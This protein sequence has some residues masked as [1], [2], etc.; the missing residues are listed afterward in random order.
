M[1]LII[2]IPCFNEAQTL[3]LTYKTLPTRIEGIDSIETLVIDDGSIDNTAEIA[4]E[5]GVTHVYRY[6]Q[7]KGLARAFSLGMEKSL[8]LGADIIVNTDAD[9]QY[10]GQ[11]IAKIVQPI[12]EEK[13]DVVVGDRQ[14]DSIEHFSLIKKKLQKIGS[15]VIRKLSHTEVRDTVSGFRAFSRDAALKLNTLTEFSHTVESLIQLGNQ[16]VIIRSVPIGTNEPLRPSR[17][18]SSIP[19]FL[20]QQLSTILRVYATYKAL[21]IFTVLGLLTILPGLMGLGRFLYFYFTS[22][23]QGHVQSLIFSALF[24]NIGFIVFMFGIIADLICNNRKLLENI[25][26]LTKKREF[27]SRSTTLVKKGST[28]ADRP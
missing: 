27:E 1:K 12:L 2:Q 16:K 21:K 7:N 5:I 4:K 10:C 9:N 19:Q 8:A 20:I 6:V 3:P 17:L 24:I 22:G 11:D 13:A 23:G 14:T 18:F 26:Y 25:L 15:T 28:H